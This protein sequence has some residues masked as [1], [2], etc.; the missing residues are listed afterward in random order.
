M[1][2]VNLRLEFCRQD[3]DHCATLPWLWASAMKQTLPW[4][5]SLVFLDLASTALVYPCLQ[6]RRQ[7]TACTALPPLLMLRVLGRWA[8][9][10]PPALL[11]A[12]PHSSFRR[13]RA[14]DKKGL[15]ENGERHTGREKAGK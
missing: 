11:W 3:P 2:A 10:A 5:C 8:V 7:A 12:F 13:V 15:E 9:S 14:G 6:L 1:T 4:E